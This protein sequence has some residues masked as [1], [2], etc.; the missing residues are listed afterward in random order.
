MSS[1]ILPESILCIVNTKYLMH[2]WLSMA[3]WFSLITT[4]THQIIGYLQYTDSIIFYWKIIIVKFTF[5]NE[6]RSYL[7]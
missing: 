4:Y 1:S 3:V 7:D 6:G 2:E 5:N